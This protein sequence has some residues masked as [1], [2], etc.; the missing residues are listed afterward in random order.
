M[1][2]AGRLRRDRFRAEDELR[3]AECGSR[4]YL[5]N[6][7]CGLDDGTTLLG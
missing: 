1:A 4:I 6:A 7:E 3:I 5:R 2:E